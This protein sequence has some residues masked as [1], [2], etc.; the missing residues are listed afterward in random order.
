MRWISNVWFR[1]RAVFAPKKMEAELREEMAFHLE[2]EAKKL[3]AQGLSPEAAHRQAWKNFGEPLRQKEKARDSWGIRWI[4][5]LRSDLRLAFRGARKSPVL[6]ATAVITIALGIG[7]ITAVFSVVNSVLLRPLPYPDPDGLVALNHTMPGVGNPSTPIGP[8]LY[9]TYR[10]Y[11]RTLEDI[12]LFRNTAQTVTGGIDPERVAVWAVTETILPMLGL[13]PILG[14]GFH[15]ED[16]SERSQNPIILTHDYWQER[17][18]A[19]PNV[20]GR[21]LTV[22]GSASPIVGVLPPS[23]TLRDQNVRL[24]SPLRLD[25]LPQSVG[26][27][28]FGAFARLG[29]GSTAEQA[30]E[31]LSSLTPL[32][33]E[34]YP[35]IPLEEL[36]RRQFGT[37][38]TPLKTAVVRGTGPVLWLLF[39]TVGIVMLLAC[40]N[41][42]NLFLVKAEGRAKDVALRKALGAS[43]ERL[44][45]Q[46]LAESLALTAIGGGLGVLVAAFCVRVLVSMAPPGL[47]RLSEIGLGPEVL[48]FTLAVTLLAGVVFGLVSVLRAGD[49]S[50]TDPLKE[51]SRGAGGGQGRARTRNALAVVQ[52]AMALVLL[53]GSGLMVRTLSAL[54]SIPPGYERPEEVI[55]FRLSL[56]GVWAPDHEA[57]GRTFQEIH[58]RLSQIPGVTSVSGA[59]SIAME[60]WQAWENLSM[61]DF[62]VP[63][64]GPSP[65]RRLNWITPGHFATMQN[66]LRAGHPFGWA[67]VMERRNVAIVSE[68]FAR[69]FW[70][71]PEDALGKRFRMG[72]EQPWKEIIGVAGDVRTRGVTEP[73]PAIVYFPYVME[74]LWGPDGFSQRGL[75]FALRSETRNPADLMVEARQ[76]V[77]A[78]NPRLPLSN[79][80]TL[81]EIFAGSIARTSFSMTM[82]GTAA[83]F[84]VI[85]G[86]VG[87]YGVISYLVSQRTREMGIRRAMGASAG[88]VSRMVLKQAGVLASMGVG[89]GLAV[90][91]GLSHLM[92]SLLFGVGRADPLTYGTVSAGLVAVVLLAS[93]LPARRAASVDPTEALKTD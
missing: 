74:G 27:W 58:R 50:L 90:A 59:A 34:L 12:G 87:V 66:P 55:T 39:G 53:V 43:R 24:V 79:V 65:L 13:N 78:V 67:D 40:T 4:H 45:R 25:R 56:P 75:R 7:G 49:R 77:W 32:A 37:I 80:R 48:L 11:S 60:N 15:K 41:V 62:P 71:R 82:L 14:R 30:S 63:E 83:L 28:S 16:T 47:P 8:A 44:A 85:L 81:D 23:G 57:V 51:G 10:D 5:D 21:T 9:L 52:V 1:I 22:N 91:F 89:L 76:A 31:E 20:L 3:M 54:R 92:V 26:N 64:G 35:G 18:D 61:E 38:A 17:F 19:D 72:A 33:C 29:P 86:M 70:E 46:S 69:E 2:M 84:A 68:T 93:Y 42:V 36:E 6:S 73:A 88:A